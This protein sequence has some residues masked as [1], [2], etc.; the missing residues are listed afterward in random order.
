MAGRTTSLSGPDTTSQ[1]KCFR[2]S[3]LRRTISHR[4][5]PRLNAW[6]QHLAPRQTL[7]RPILLAIVINRH[8]GHRLRQHHPR[9]LRSG[10]NM[11]IRRQQ[12]RIIQCPNPNERNERPSAGVMTPECHRTFR[13]AANFLPASTFGR[14]VD[15]GKL[16]AEQFDP[17]TLDHRVECERS[18]GLTL[19]PAAMAAMNEKRRRKQAIPNELA[20]ATAFDGI[21]RRNS[22]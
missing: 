14:C 16:A 22:H 17:V 15:P 10:K 7:R 12:I 5:N 20:V 6:Q 4:R 3:N 11:N 8:R 13:T 18:P 2:T 1:V 19:A 21:V 9:L